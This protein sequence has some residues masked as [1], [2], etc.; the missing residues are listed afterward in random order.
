MSISTR[1]VLV[2]FLLIYSFYFRTWGKLNIFISTCSVHL[3]IETHWVLH[4]IALRSAPSIH[5]LIKI[6]VRLVP[7]EAFVTTVQLICIDLLFSF[8]FNYTHCVGPSITRPLHNHQVSETISSS[9]LKGQ[10]IKLH[11]S[12]K[13]FFWFVFFHTSSM[14]KKSHEKAL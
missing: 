14:L 7:V 2:W 5:L 10:N 13:M 6:L 9:H 11:L 1:P 8:L 3:V 12:S 4:W